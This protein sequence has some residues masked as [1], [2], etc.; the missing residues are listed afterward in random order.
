MAERLRNATSP[1]L[2]QHADNPVDWW[3]W[4]D[5][6]FAAARDRDVPVMLSVGY[7]ACHWCHVMAHESFEDPPTAA[8]LNETVVAI[9]VDREERP[10]VDA[11]YMTATQAMTGQGGWP[12][13][14]FMTPAREPFY[15]GTYFPRDRFQ[16]LVLGVA[17]AWREDRGGV[18]GQAER[19]SAALAEQAAP[20]RDGEGEGAADLAAVSDQAVATLVR[21]FDRRGGGF[22]SA[23]KFPPS[24]VC[25]FLLRRS[26]RPAASAAAKEGGP[27]AGLDPAGTQALE[28]AVGTA[29]AMA[30]GGMYD[31]LGGGFARYSVDADW[32]VPHFEK[33]LYDNALLAR[34]Y[35]HLWRRTGDP[36]ARRVARDTC[37]WMIRE[38][39]TGEG[40]FAAALD[41]DSDGEEGLFYTW[42]PAELRDVLGPGDAQYAAQAFGVTEGGT[43]EHGRSVLQRR[44][45]PDDDERFGRV[46]AALLEARA[47]RVRP[48]RDDKVVT[49][50]NGLAIAA[51][52]ECGLLFD[53]PEFIAA[54]DGAA[55]LLARVHLAD[56]R[57]ARTSRAGQAGP[58]AGVLEDYA[59]L[60]DGLLVLSGVTGQARWVSMA[61][62]LLETALTRFTDGTGGFYDTPDDGEPLLYRPADP[63]D[64]PTPSG[65]FAVAG[66]LLSYA[67]LTGSARHHEAA[68]AALR[69]LAPIAAQY[70]RA[71]GAGLA[72]AEALIAGP[73]EIAVVGPPGDP[74]TAALHRTA[75]LAAPPGAVIALGD[76]T[77]ADTLGEQGVPLLYGRRLMNGY[78]TVY[79]CRNFTCRAPVS[80]LMELRDVLGYPAD[81]PPD[82][83]KLDSPVV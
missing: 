6:A 16:R 29:Q 55:G 22:G 9:K 62:E 51:L 1:Y 24:M 59:C 12:M 47:A 81:V 14:V 27:A 56:G 80:D 82:G 43:F 60:A 83:Q 13:T 64:G 70:P 58:S 21:Q 7:S 75:M 4:S 49:A 35:A 63:A 8:L 3:P 65:T 66:A 69:P 11:V 79:V 10:D 72:V 26:E 54:A 45:D 23:P 33:M 42:T 36:L 28:M 48:G 57:L 37:A 71:A 46:S 68:A 74:R 31:Q 32:I 2:L 76:G 30:R 15:C 50:W 41:A 53:D 44:S 77:A 38:L 67:A 39:G 40:G 73:A 20:W 17:K 34:F 52:A 61:G 25:E 5:E 78:P 18:T 19:I